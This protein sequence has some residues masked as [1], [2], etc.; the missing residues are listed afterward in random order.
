MK[1]RKVIF[2]IIIFIIIGELLIRID[3]KFLILKNST[4]QIEA[5]IEES[6]VKKEID[7]SS[8]KIDS[9]QYRILVIGDSY[10]NG[11]GI[12]SKEKFSK[13]LSQSIEDTNL[14]NKNLLVLDVSRPSNNTMDNFATFLHYQPKFR[15]HVIIWAYN[16][17]DIIG[18][19]S[20]QLK[21]KDPKKLNSN[22]PKRLPKER[23]GPKALMKSIYSYSE[24]L[25]HLS[26]ELQKELKVNGIVLP[27]GDFYYLIEKAYSKEDKNWFETKQILNNVV[28]ICR[29]SNTKFI[30]YNMPEFNLLQEE[31]LFSKIDDA[32]DN[33]SKSNKY[34]TYIN[35]RDDFEGVVDDTY[36]ISKY[37]GHPNKLAH[38]IIANRIAEIILSELRSNK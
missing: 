9:S 12:D 26:T 33:Y 37:D 2:Y 14:I 7:N 23:K 22:P 25:R 5:I 34:I 16:F 28:E 30:L 31:N 17:N 1:K 6:S 24:L 8:F 10:I 38:A 3:K 15:P 29:E 11:G 32:F 27:F 35:G 36:L 21:E 18:G 13:K 19:I 4:I 20:A